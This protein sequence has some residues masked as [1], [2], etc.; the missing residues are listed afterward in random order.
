MVD[1]IVPDTFDKVTVTSSAVCGIH[2][3]AN[4]NPFQYWTDVIVAVNPDG[5]VSGTA[6][7]KLVAGQLKR[8]VSDAMPDSADWAA[9]SQDTFAVTRVRCVDE[10]EIDVEKASKRATDARPKTI[11]ASKTSTRVSPRSSRRGNDAQPKREPWAFLYPGM[12]RRRILVPT[13]TPETRRPTGDCLE[14]IFVPSSIV[15]DPGA[16]ASTM[17]APFF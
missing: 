6:T 3:V 8:L 17:P 1:K 12:E 2:V 14:P 10:A 16:T 15:I 11:R 5:A 7:L 9:A 4:L 13:W